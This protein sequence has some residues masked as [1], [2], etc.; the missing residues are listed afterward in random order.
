[1]AGDQSSQEIDISPD[2]KSCHNKGPCQVVACLV[3]G[4]N[5]SV[6]R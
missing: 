1:L 2:G 4:D 6:V 5:T 3:S